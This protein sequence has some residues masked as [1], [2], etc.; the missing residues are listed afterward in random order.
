P[1]RDVDYSSY[2]SDQVQRAGL[3]GHVFFV[4]E[5]SFIDSAYAKADVFLLSS[6]LDP[7]P[8]VA[9][10]AMFSGVPVVC[11]D[12]CSGIADFLHRIEM[13]P[14]CVARYLDT[15]DVAAKL[16][17][18]AASASLRS[19]IGGIIGAAAR[20]HFDMSRYVQEVESIALAAVHE[21]SKLEMPP[22]QPA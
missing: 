14:R 20:H 9:I 19:E 10:D 18:F 12:R 13:G 22:A 1:D 15:E 7:L 4:G 2:L 21:R 3:S 8:N 5:T 6:R 17:D 16:L 11:F